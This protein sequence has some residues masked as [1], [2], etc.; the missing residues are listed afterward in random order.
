MGIKSLKKFAAACLDIS[1][2]GLYKHCICD[3]LVLHAYI[4]P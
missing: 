1:L 3:I 2:H 4:I